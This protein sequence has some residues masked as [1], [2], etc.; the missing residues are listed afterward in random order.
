M[1]LGLT[2]TVV[3][4]YSTLLTATN[5]LQALCNQQPTAICNFYSNIVYSI[6]SFYVYG[7]TSPLTRHFALP[8]LIHGG[9]VTS[10]R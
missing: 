9:H 8:F 5:S 2:I 4:F 7:T 10:A 3:G 6:G 1:K